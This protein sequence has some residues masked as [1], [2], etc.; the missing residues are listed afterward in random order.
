MTLLKFISLKKRKL[1]SR[2]LEYKNYPVFVL[3]PQINMF[4]MFSLKLTRQWQT[5]FSCTLGCFYIPKKGQ[6]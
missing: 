6:K 5:N 3:R 2:D 1:W 4:G